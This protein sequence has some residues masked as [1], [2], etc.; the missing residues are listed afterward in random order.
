MIIIIIRQGCQ[1]SKNGQ[2]TKF[3]EVRG[4]FRNYIISEAGRIGILNMS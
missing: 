2:G 3:F 4:K 1:R